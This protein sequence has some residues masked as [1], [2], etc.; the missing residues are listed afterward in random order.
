MISKANRGHRTHYNYNTSEDK[1]AKQRVV[2]TSDNQTSDDT[3][4]LL[5]KPFRAEHEEMRRNVKN[6]S[7]H[8]R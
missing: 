3:H 7:R 8:N 1:R 5:G 4:T 6:H 2:F